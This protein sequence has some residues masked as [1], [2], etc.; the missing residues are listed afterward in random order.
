MIAADSPFRATECV[1]CGDVILGGRAAGLAWRVERY[2]VPRSHALTL[3]RYGV[4]VLLLYRREEAMHGDFWD[5]VSDDLSTPHRHLVV[6]H[7][8]GSSFNQGA[9]ATP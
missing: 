1:R 6:P 5:P 2:A 8:C 3:K 4:P 9:K 7:V